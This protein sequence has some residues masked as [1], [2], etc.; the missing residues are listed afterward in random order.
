MA[1]ARTRCIGMDVHQD[2]IAVA[3]RAQDHGAE[4]TY[5]GAMGTRLCDIEHLVRTMPAQAPP[6]L[7]GYAAGPCGSWL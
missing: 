3:Y 7:F 2:A 5:R 1:Q 6:L 4:G